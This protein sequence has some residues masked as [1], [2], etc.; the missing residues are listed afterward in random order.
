[1]NIDKNKLCTLWY[2]D[3]NGKRIPCD[4]KELVQPEGAVYQI[5]QFPNVLHTTYLV[6]IRQEDVD[7]C[8]HPRKHVAPTYGWKDGIVGRVCKCCHGTQLKKKWHFWPRKWDGTGSYELMTGHA[9]WSEDLVLKMANSGGYTLKEAI[10]VVAQSCERCM[11]ALANKYGLSWGYGENGEE[12]NK[13]NTSC[14][15]CRTDTNDTPPA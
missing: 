9:S 6:L 4:D 3:A 14:M 8:K 7:K 10:L 1:M 11:N 2:E 13:C 12:W 15:F 5:S